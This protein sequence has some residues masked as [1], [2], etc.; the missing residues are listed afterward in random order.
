MDCAN[1]NRRQAL[2]F[3]ATF[4]S[5]AFA[6][7]ILSAAGAPD[8][9]LLF[10]NL[11]GALD[12]LAALAPAGDPAYEAIREGLSL[13]KDGGAAGIAVDNFFVLNPNMPELGKL[14]KAG[15]AIVC[16]AVASPYRGRSHFDGQDVL[17]SGQPVPGLT[18]T[19]WLNRLIALLPAGEP[20]RSSDALALGSSVPLILRGPQPVVSWMPAG[21]PEVSSDTRMRVMD[22]YTHT[23]PELAN[24]MA[25]AL[26]LEAATGNEATMTAA[27]ENAMDAELK[28][29]VRQFAEIA[30]AAGKLLAK[31]EGPRV[32]ALTYNG[33]DTHR[34]QGQVD[35]RLGKLLQALDGAIGALHRQLEPVWKDT[36]IV[37]ATE[38]G[39]TVRINGTLGTDHGTGTIA[40][41]LGGG[42]KGGRVLADWPGLAEAALFE[43]RDLKPTTDLRAVLKGVL[44][45]HWDIGEQ[46]LADTVFPDS[47]SVRPVPGLLS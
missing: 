2:L 36:V 34:S 17:E 33:W 47:G 22:L 42:L 28:G 4:A 26:K 43:G 37:V 23:D 14:L 27:L 24:L 1:L 10:V 18:R 29:A 7:K 45:E 44:T 40:I 5:W 16:H 9:R 20:V 12:G 38:F 32:A 13:D 6:P 25:E 46:A 21:F 11:T 30:T 15:H 31:P 35:G 39:R 3:G 19:G 8:R 41:L